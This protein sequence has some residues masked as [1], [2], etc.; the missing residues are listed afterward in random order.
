MPLTR[1][2]GP[3]PIASSRIKWL[4]AALLTSYGSL[5]LFGTT[6]LAE[7]VSTTEASR[8]CSFRIFAASSASTWL[9][10]TLMLIAR[11]QVCSGG[12]PG[13]GVGKIAA[14]LI[15]ASR[16]PNRITVARNAAAMLS[17]ELRSSATP[18]TSSGED[19]A[20]GFLGDRFSAGGVEIGHHDVG[21]AFR[22]QQR[23]LAADAARAADHDGDAPA[24]FPFGRHPLELGFFECPVFDAEGLRPRQRDVVPVVL[25]LRRL[26]GMARLRRRAGL[27]VGILERVRTRHDVDGVDEELRGDAR[28][29]LV[30]AEP[31]QPDAGDHHDRRV[32]IA[33][34]RRVLLGV[35]LVVR[36]RSPRGR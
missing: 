30:L 5:P 22:E 1:T 10:V 13:A 4:I 11:P 3:R 18:S 24:E 12:V 27:G 14:V 15:T 6:A 17:R 32:R 35:R 8:P 31:E 25:E 33:Q 21:A 9:L 28:F 2:S 20:A 29:A 26:I 23:H 7:L 34:R 36:L 16:P 19:S